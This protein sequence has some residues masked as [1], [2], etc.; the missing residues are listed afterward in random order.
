MSIKGIYNSMKNSGL[1][2][3]TGKITQPMLDEFVNLLNDAQPTD[4][5]ERGSKKIVLSM[6][7]KSKRSFG[8]FVRKSGMHELVL[9][10][11]GFNIV[12][13]FGLE[14]LVKLQWDD[15]TSR[16]HIESLV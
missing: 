16:F 5:M 8:E 13:H 7:F 6:F 4:D 9:Y 12:G 10:T 11:P 15:E 1:V 14:R 2:S 3:G